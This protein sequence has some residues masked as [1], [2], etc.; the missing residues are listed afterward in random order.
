MIQQQYIISEKLNI[1]ELGQVLG[2]IFET[3]TEC[4]GRAE[5]HPNELY[6]HLKD[7]GHTKTNLSPKTT[8]AEE[9]Q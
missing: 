1:F 7:I 9:N 4:C 8:S 2:N 5:T 6:L 3:G